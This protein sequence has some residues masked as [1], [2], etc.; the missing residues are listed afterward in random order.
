MKN[1]ENKYF[2][3]EGNIGA[4]KSTL[5]QKLAKNYRAECLLEKF[6]ENPFLES[7]YKNKKRFALAVE[8]FFLTQRHNQL[9]TIQDFNFKN[10]SL[11]ADFSFEKTSIFAQKTLQNQ[12]L[13][14]FKDLDKIVSQNAPKP[15]LWI[16]LD[17]N[18]SKLKSNIKKRNRAFEKEI[19]E[20]YLQSIS[21]SYME[22]MQK[23][24]SHSFLII[25]CNLLDFVNSKTDFNN[26]LKLLKKDFP[27]GIT[28]V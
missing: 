16:Y 14:L 18:I 22:F 2:V 9:K 8:T 3:I 17:A 24:K 7:F 25:D 6:V 19:S 28:K 11:F 1:N 27:K 15:D 23:N 12:E 13:K 10:K 5:A 26:I 4:G 21:D 20:T